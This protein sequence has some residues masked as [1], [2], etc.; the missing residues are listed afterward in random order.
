MKVLKMVMVVKAAV[1]KDTIRRRDGRAKKIGVEEDAVDE[2]GADQF[3]PT[4]SATDVTNMVTMRTM[5]TPTNVTI[6]AE[7]HEHS[8]PVPR[9]TSRLAHVSMSLN[10]RI[11]I[12]YT[13][14]FGSASRN[15]RLKNDI[16]RS[17]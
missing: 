6:V 7:G 8:R 2:E 4:F 9:P 11:T 14:P 1:M 17:I 13:G 12:A 5:V 3:T 10:D 16:F 15:S